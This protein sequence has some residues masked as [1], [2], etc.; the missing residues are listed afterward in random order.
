MKILI[1]S[2]SHGYLS[3]LEA[4]LQKEAD[5]DMILH[6][7]DGG[8]DLS[9]MTEYTAGK[10]VYVCRGNC[11]S[12]VYGFP[13]SVTTVV[14]GATVF[15]CHGHRYGVKYGLERLYF[16]AK[17]AGAK[18]CLFGHTHQPYSDF[19]DNFFMVNPGS[20]AGGCYAVAE[21]NHG[22]VKTLN[23]SLDRR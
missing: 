21:I 10:P 20:A 16:A 8:G 4:I 9:L 2:D 13:E 14:E 17:E 23:K 12:E 6:L 18:L 5:A 3:R 1:L 19:I 15:A 11:D 7:G 22:E